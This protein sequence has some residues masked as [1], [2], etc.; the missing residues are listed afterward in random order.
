MKYKKVCF[1]KYSFLCRTLMW[2]Y[3]HV[4]YLYNNVKIFIQ[5]FPEWRPLDLFMIRMQQESLHMDTDSYIRPLA[6][7]GNTPYEI[8]S[9]FSYPFRFHIKGKI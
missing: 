8:K 4:Q 5:I 9:L 2:I 3:F 7:A 6:Y 1:Q